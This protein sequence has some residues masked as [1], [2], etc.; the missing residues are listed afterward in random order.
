MGPDRDGILDVRKH[1]MARPK[2]S[3][4]TPAELEVLQLLW[5]HG[6]STVRQVMERLHP[7]RPRGYTTVM[8]LLNVMHEKGLLK[9]KPDGRAFIYSAR[10]DQAKTLKRMVG[11]LLSRAFQGS[12]SALVTHLLEQADPS[13]EELEVIRQVIANYGHEQGDD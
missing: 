9:R 6:P 12:T 4:P 11:D 8:S 13:E 1:A 3:H 7:R 5:Q 10:V 2:H